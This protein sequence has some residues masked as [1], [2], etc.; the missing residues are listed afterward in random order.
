MSLTELQAIERSSVI[1]SY[2]RFPVEFVRGEGA[3]L[4][5][6]RAASTSIFSAAFR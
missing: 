1:P 3:Y 6:D 5:D 4:W 2:A